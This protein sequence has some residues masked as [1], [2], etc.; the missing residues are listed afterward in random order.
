MKGWLLKL[1]LF[2]L[3]SLLGL[4]IA[5]AWFVPPMLDWSQYRGDLAEL[6]SD[7]LGRAVTIEGPISLSLLPEPI[8]TASRVSVPDNQDGVTIAVAELRVRLALPALL[9]G[10]IDAQEVVLRGLDVRLPWPLGRDRLAMQAPLW[11]SSITARVQDGKLTVGSLTATGIDATLG[12]VPETGSYAVAGTAQISGQAWHMTARL[13]RTGGDGAA[14]L[15]LSLDG[16]GKMQGLGAMFTGQIAAD[17]TLGGRVS[18]SG[19]DLSRLLAAPA[20]PFKAEGRLSIAGGLAVADELAVEIAGSPARGTVA[21]RLEPSLRLD[22]SIAA[23][24]LD[25]DAWLPALLRGAGSQIATSIPTGVDLSSEAAT[26]LGGTLRGLRGNF[27]IAPSLVTL[28]DVAATLPGDAQL[29]LAG[30]FRQRAEAGLRFDGTGAISAANLRTTLAWLEAAG[31]TPLASLPGEVMRTA[32]LRAAVTADINIPGVAALQIGLTD[33]NGIVDESHIQGDMTLRPGNRLGISGTLG[34]DKLALDPWLSGKPP[35]LAGLPTRLGR[36]DLDM[37]IRADQATLRNQTLAPV[38]IDALLE[39]GRLTLR[40]LDLQSTGARLVASGVINDTGRIADGHL[41][42]T[43][44][45]ETLAPLVTMW[46]PAFAPLAAHLPRGAL[47]LNAL[48]SG[49]PEAQAWRAVADLGDLHV[50]AQPVMDLPGARWTSSLSLRH[51]GAPRL[52]DTIGLGGTASWLGDGS[53]SFSGNLAGTGFILAPDRIASDAF[54]LSAGRLRASGALALDRAGTP[55]V[56]GRIV[57]E[58]LPLPLPYPRALDPLPVTLLSGLQVAMK[59]EAGQVLGGLSPMLQQAAASMSLNGGVLRFENFSA[60]LDG[61]ALSGGVTLDS[62]AQP[63]TLNAD[64][65]LSGAHPDGAVFDLPIDVAGGMIDSHAKL[66]A[67]GYSAGA[68]LSTLSGSWD[69]QA[70]DGSLVGVDLG[71]F[72]PQLVDADLRAALAGGATPFDR[73]DITAKLHNGAATITESR[74]VAPSGTGTLLGL[75][76]IAGRLAEL[77]LSLRPAVQDP[78]EIAVRLSGSLASPIRTPEIADAG[79]WRAEHH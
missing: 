75:L 46:A 30:Q 49:P 39:T 28:Q 9:S 13:T 73:F 58:T 16:Q 1:V 20:V 59:I 7:K 54:D 8:L 68:L 67:S 71:A 50:E 22:V 52:L 76:D 34:M 60:K 66:S 33:L 63:P 51:P 69:V 72:G 27:E 48:I 18:G 62:N 32:N 42:V 36:M 4:T 24:R 65:S 15:D 31:L 43:A 40:R 74:L 38:V 55:K 10:Q 78:P 45:T 2:G 61:G 44:A 41:E 77:R 56:T 57:A 25:L 35:S 64:L 26:L 29:T 5:A 53:L 79:R 37:Q 47:A 6:V 19:P 12:L 70:R 17:G 11:L 21:L 14:G 23:S 3:P